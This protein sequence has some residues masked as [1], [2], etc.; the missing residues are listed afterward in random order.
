MRRTRYSLSSPLIWRVS[1]SSVFGPMI[2]VNNRFA[3][4]ESHVSGTPSLGTSLT[5][6]QSA[7]SAF[8]QVRAQSGLTDRGPIWWAGSGSVRITRPEAA[9]SAR[10]H[11]RVVDTSAHGLYKARAQ[12]PGQ[13][14]GRDRRHS[15]PGGSTAAV[16]TTENA[17]P[18]SEAARAGLEERYERFECCGARRALALA[19]RVRPG[20]AAARRPPPPGAADRARASRRRLPSPADPPARRGSCSSRPWSGRPSSAG[21]TTSSTGIATSSTTPPASRSPTAGS[22]PA[23]WFTLACALLLV[24]PSPS[25]GLVAGSTYLIALAIG[26]LGNVALRRGCCRGCRGRRRS[27][28]T[29]P[30]CRTAAGAAARRSP[31]RSAPHR[32]S[33]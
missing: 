18:T 30:S 21:T 16:G 15:D 17:L 33:R 12:A 25:N 32:R 31:S 4:G 9:E 11:A 1:M 3:D 24:V 5:R 2:W 6:P 7:P 14:R 10:R 29:P 26:L 13:A 22:T 20:P 27:R 28:S 19:D 23:P 8:L